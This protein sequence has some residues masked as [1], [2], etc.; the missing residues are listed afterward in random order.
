M[1][2]KSNFMKYLE[3]PVYLW[4]AVHRPD[5]LPLDS[6][7]LKLRFAMGNVV[8]DF[9]R[10]LFEGGQEVK[11]FNS[12]GWKNTQKLIADGAKLLY[13]PTV[14]AGELTCRAD[15]LE[16]E[17]G[18]WSLNEVKSATSVKGHYPFDVAFQK[19]C[20]ENAGI[21]LARTNLIY[22][23]NKY[24]R[25]GEV[26][27]KKLF[28]VEDIS[29]IVDEK[30][31][32][33][34][35]LV[36]LALVVANRKTAPDTKFL[37]TCPNPKSCAWLEIYNESVGKK[38]VKTIIEE[39]TDAKG[40][41]KQLDALEYPLYFL[42]YETYGPA[43]PLYDGTRPYQNIPF[44]YSLG[45]K[46][47]P[48][49]E[50]TYTEFLARKSE[51]PVP[52]LLAQ[53]KKDLGPTGSVITWNMS[54]EKAR[55]N[56]MGIAEPSYAEFLNGVND[57]VFDLMPIFK[58]KNQLYVRND[59]EGSHSL[60]AVVPVMC[61]EL[62]YDNLAIQEGATASASWPILTGDTVSA[63]EKVKLA[64][65]MLKYCKRDTETMVCILEKLEAEINANA[66][67]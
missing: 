63:T 49:A 5:L 25:Q 3:C 6:P 57:R 65:D 36:E 28:A 14:V 54:F 67:L 59:F 45:L 55:N 10:K 43:I 12:E 37:A 61:P 26:E 64:D 52:A 56:E 31:D 18:V 15:I 44:Q 58:I 38:P 19:I 24:V 32:E 51:N 13:Q 22:I 9:A 23:N 35:K 39:T 47:T 17:N 33:V 4:M 41:K 66:C 29:E 60:K 46:K 27:L 62:S 40:I 2:T 48:D 50:T 30:M 8:D 1:L 53:L 34:K 42:D 20:F 16:M 21:K 7:D 11:G